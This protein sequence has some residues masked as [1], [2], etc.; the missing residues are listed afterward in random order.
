MLSNIHAL[1]HRLH[2]PDAGILLIRIAVGLIFLLHGWSKL[3][4][5]DNLV[6]WF[7]TLGFPGFLAYFVAWSE[8]LGGL[9]LIVG[10][11]VRYVGILLG[12]IMA[13]AII[14][15]HLGKG[16]SVATGGY[17]FALVLM[18]GAFAITTFGAGAYS[19]ARYLKG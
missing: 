9:A 2:N 18:L 12:I 4:G 5:M 7:A 3:E 11:F 17:E 8:V 1:V 15:V 13:V 14:K 19:L 16:Y 10:I 6:A